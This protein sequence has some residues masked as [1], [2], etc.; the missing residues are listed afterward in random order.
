MDFNILDSKGR[1]C[2]YDVLFNEVSPGSFEMFGQETRDSKPFGNKTRVYASHSWRELE[3]RAHSL[4]HNAKERLKA[5][6]GELNDMHIA[7][8]TVMREIAATDC[9]EI[10]PKSSGDGSE[11]VGGLRALLI[12]WV[13]ILDKGKTD[14]GEKTTL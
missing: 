6:Y 14:H 13:E 8:N 7:Y 5:K 4:E 9:F 3:I 12:N 10:D 11:D 2:G 1:N